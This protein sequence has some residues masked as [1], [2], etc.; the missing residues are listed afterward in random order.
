MSREAPSQDLEIDSWLFYSNSSSHSS[1]PSAAATPI[2]CK[3]KK[4]LNLF[5]VFTYEAKLQIMFLKIPRKSANFAFVL[6]TLASVRPCSVRPWTFMVR[7]ELTETFAFCEFSAKSRKF[8]PAK[9]LRA[10]IPESLF[11]RKIPEEVIR[12]S[13]FQTLKNFNFFYFYFFCSFNHSQFLVWIPL[14][15]LFK[16]IFTFLVQ[17]WYVLYSSPHTRFL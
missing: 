12:D 8:D 2:C 5:L 15:S 16:V 3:L 9:I 7:L 6:I 4:K 13:L 10:V 17:I 1:L 14:N 11:Q